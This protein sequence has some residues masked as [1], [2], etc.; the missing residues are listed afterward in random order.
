MTT[1]YSRKTGAPAGGF[2]PFPAGAAEIV[3]TSVYMDGLTPEDR[4][5]LKPEIGWVKPAYWDTGELEVILREH[6]PE[7]PVVYWTLETCFEK[8]L[9]SES[10]TVLCSRSEHVYY[11]SVRSSEARA[12]ITGPYSLQG[13]VLSG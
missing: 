7:G 9:T 1:K 8:A 12:V 4:I 11:L 3:L 10:C 13:S 2:A 6:S 5:V